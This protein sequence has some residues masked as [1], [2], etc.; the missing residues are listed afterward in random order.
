MP[1]QWGFGYA[2]LHLRNLLRPLLPEHVR[3]HL[4]QA[5]LLHVVLQRLLSDCPDEVAQGKRRQR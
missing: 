5:D 4:D 2:T 3:V 1:A